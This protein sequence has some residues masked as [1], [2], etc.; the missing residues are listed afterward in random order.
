MFFKNNYFYYFQD[1]GNNIQDNL[2]KY[3]KIHL[4]LMHK[5]YLKSPKRTI[6]LSKETL[7]HAH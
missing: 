4:S 3:K 6:G 2:H 1:K 5:F 7:K